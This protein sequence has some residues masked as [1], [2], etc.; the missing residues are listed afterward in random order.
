MFNEDLS[1]FFNDFSETVVYS[2][3]G[4][5]TEINAIVD[6]DVNLYGYE[7]EIIGK[8]STF[9]TDHVDLEI[10]GVI[11]YLSNS[12]TIDSIISNDGKLINV[13]TVKQ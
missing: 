5:N 13:S 8:T 12:Y 11:T 2:N 4:F 10:G 9:I 1:E 3:N 7:G 6:H